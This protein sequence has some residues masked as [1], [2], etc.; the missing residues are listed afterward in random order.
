LSPKDGWVRQLLG[1]DA[2][3]GH[4]HNQ[5][6]VVDFSC[7]NNI[8]SCAE[9]HRLLLEI[10]FDNRQAVGTNIFKLE[11]SARNF[12]DKTR[13]IAIGVII[14]ADRKSL[15]S[16]GW[17]AG[18]ADEEEYQ[19]ALSTAYKEYLSSSISLMVLRG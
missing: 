11:T 18:V 5:N 19:V 13:G 3:P 9:R 17:D 8:Q 1:I 15:K 14:C 10:C 7:D 4:L 2:I 16:G 6:Y 12:R